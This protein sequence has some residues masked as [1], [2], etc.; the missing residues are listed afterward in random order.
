MSTDTK[1][2][3]SRSRARARTLSASASLSLC[4]P[5][6]LSISP[7][8]S[9]VEFVRDLVWAEYDRTGVFGGE[10]EGGGMRR[11]Q[12]RLGPSYFY[13]SIVLGPL[14]ILLW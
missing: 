1:C 9:L 8:L 11:G 10:E 7:S 5:V 4:L 12:E 2:S 6:C 3:D 14:N 13:I